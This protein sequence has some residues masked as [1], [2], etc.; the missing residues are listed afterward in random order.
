MSTKRAPPTPGPTDNFDAR[1]TI[2]DLENFWGDFL[3]AWPRTE[4]LDELV[5]WLRVKLDMTTQEAARWPG[6]KKDGAE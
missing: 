4:P 6:R 5:N 1:G 3:A 2:Y